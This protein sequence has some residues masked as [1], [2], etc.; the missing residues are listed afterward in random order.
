MS[1]DRLARNSHVWCCRLDRPVVEGIAFD[2]KRVLPCMGFGR[3]L[4]TVFSGSPIYPRRK[5][6]WRPVLRQFRTPENP[7]RPGMPNALLSERPNCLRAAQIAPAMKLTAVR[8]T[9]AP[10]TNKINSVAL[11]ELNGGAFS[12]SGFGLTLIFVHLLECFYAHH[13]IAFITQ[14]NKRILACQ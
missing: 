8:S 2:A 12:F 5:E 14:S 3:T 4:F 6:R 13:L 9:A 7:G 10:T 11:C 1:K